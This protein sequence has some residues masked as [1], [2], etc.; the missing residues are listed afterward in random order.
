MELLIG[1]LYYVVPFIVLLGILVFVHEFG[2]YIIAKISGVKVAEFSI[3]FGKKLWGAKDRSGTEWKICL[4]PLGGYC[5]FLG[6]GDA[7]SATNEAEELSEE[8]KKY[9]FAF[10]NP[11]KKLA[12]VIAGPAA[13]YVF[14]ILVFAGVFYFMGKIDFP[15]VVGEVIKGSAAE[16]AGILAGDRFLKVNGKPVSDFTELRQ[17]VDLNTAEKIKV[18]I[19]RDG[20][21]LNLEFPLQVV[22]LEDELNQNSHPKPMLGVRSINVIEIKPEKV[23]LAE[24][25]LSATNE[26]WRI[27]DMTLRGLGQMITG[28]R[29]TEEV[30]GIIR[31]AEMSGDISKQSGGIDFLVFMALLSINL[32]LL[33]LFPIPLLDG[34]H[35]VIYLIEIALG[36]ELSDN[37]KN[38]IFKCGLIILIS[39]MVFATYNDFIHLFNRWFS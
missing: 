27:T 30:G 11:F 39:L 22:T 15:P 28:K 31:I 3:G 37:I 24:A 13:N 18:E 5:K 23:S 12:I 19:E 20:K 38:N 14:A 25:F 26:T 33:N 21:L 9:A 8:D 6:D 1:A 7:S 16:K 2:H 35:V 4:I 32:G 36:R 17:E 34:G 29:G 10:Q